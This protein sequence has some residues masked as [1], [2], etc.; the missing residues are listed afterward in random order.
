MTEK[1]Y[2]FFRGKFKP[3][4]HTLSKEEQDA[5]EAKLGEAWDLAGAKSLTGAIIYTSWS[6]DWEWF[7]VEEFSSMEA[8]QQWREEMARQGWET[9]TE[10]ENLIG[11]HRESAN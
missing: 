11:I 4:W 2:R 1:I 6:S 9:Y 7:G 8:V 5:R 10:H 3:E